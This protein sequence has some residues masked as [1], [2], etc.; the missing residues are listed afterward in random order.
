MSKRAWYIKN[1]RIAGGVIAMAQFHACQSH[2]SC[3]LAP[4]AWPRLSRKRSPNPSITL[5][6]CCGMGSPRLAATSPDPDP[7]PDADVDDHG[8]QEVEAVEASGAVPGALAQLHP[9]RLARARTLPIARGAGP[10]AGQTLEDTGSDW[11]R[12]ADPFFLSNKERKVKERELN[13]IQSNPM[14]CAALRCDATE[15]EV[16]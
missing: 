13:P 14:R 11:C 4:W 7:D 16:K 1:A 3:I 6:G 15:S 5:R 12:S 10:Q 2:R 8:A 9:H